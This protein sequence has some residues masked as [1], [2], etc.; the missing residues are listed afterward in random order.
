MALTF[1]RAAI[2]ASALFLALFLARFLLAAAVTAEFGEP[3]FSDNQAFELQRKNYASVKQLAPIA[4]G[5][6]APSGDV[7]KYEKIATLAQTSRAFDEDKQKILDAVTA[8]QGIVQLE[9]ASG[10]KGRR[11][12]TL[13]IG[14]PPEKFDAFVEATKG[15]GKNAQ[16]DIVKNDKTNEYLQLQAKRTTLEK[17]RAALEEVKGS[18]GSVEE[19]VTVQNRLTEIEQQIQDL[20]VSLGEFDTQNEL[21]TVKLSLSEMRS[22]PPTSLAHRAFD[23]F[24][25]TAYWYTIAAFGFFLIVIGG[26]LATALAAFAWRMVGQAKAAL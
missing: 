25:W 10:L 18:G 16:I 6:G 20:G 15:L 14:V 9:R 23:A 12:L 13:G 5:A 22:V 24:E 8:H 1:K 17:A 26:W 4:A 11:V 3:I 7:Q 2:I 21:C 19:R